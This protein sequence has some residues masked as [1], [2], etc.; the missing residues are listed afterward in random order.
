MDISMA[1][2]ASG[3]ASLSLLCVDDDPQI[4]IL[5]KEL[6]RREPGFIV[7]TSTSA[8]EAL[9]LMETRHYDA[10]LS[11]YYMPEMDGIGLLKEI[12]SRG[13]PALFVIFTGRHI[14]S[15]AIETL[16]NG[17]NF[18]IQKGAA[19]LEDIPKL[20]E[21]L[22]SHRR[23]DENG[24]PV[25][26][27][28]SRF[29]IFT[30]SG[31]ELLASILPDGSITVTNDAWTSELGSE[32]FFAHIPEPDQAEVKKLVA[33]LSPE[34][35]AVYVECQTILRDGKKKR[36]QWG[37]TAF[38]DDGGAP[39]EY[40]AHGR[41]LTGMVTL[42][43]V[44]ETVPGSAGPGKAPLPAGPGGETAR[45]GTAGA[46][47]NGASLARIAKSVAQV[48]YPIFAVD[49]SGTIIAWN[50]AIAD[51]TGVAAESML[52]K[53]DRA[54]AEPVYGRRQP[55]LVDYI[56]P[57]PGDAGQPLPALIKRDG[58]AYI[59]G[60][61]EVTLKGKAMHIVGRATAIR[62][63]SGTIIGAVQ[64][65]LASE[66]HAA[67]TID[68]LLEEEHYLGGVSSVI[69]K[70]TGKGLAGAIAGAIGSASGGY[71]VYATDQRLFIIH[72]PELDA[73]RN[74]GVQFG[75]FLFD[76]LFGTN[77]DIRSRSIRDLEQ[78]K[79]FAVWKNDLVSIEMKKP[80]LLA[81]YLV[82][83]TRNG[84]SFRIY[85]DHQKAF[86]HIEQLMMLFSPE[87][88]KDWTQSEESGE[89]AWIDE[90]QGFDVIGN[91]R[92]DKPVRPQAA[93]GPVTV[94]AHGAGTVSPLAAGDSQNPWADLRT[95]IEPIQYPILAIDRDGKVIA[96]NQAI[97]RLTGIAADAMIGRGDGAYSLPF[98]GEP[99]PMLIDYIVMPPDTDIPAA[100]PAISRE[101]DTFIGDM[102]SV[103][104]GGRP[105]LLWGKG[106]GIYD[107]KGTL[108]AAI[109]SIL[110]SE[111]P[112]PKYADDDLFEERYIGGISSI[113]VKPGREGTA[114]AIAG[115]IGSAPGGYGVYA[116]DQRL[117]IIHNPELDPTKTGGVQFGTFIL[118][119][120]FG[121]TVDTRPF[122][123]GELEGRSVFEVR[124]RDIT[125]IE[126]K[127]PKILAGFL[128]FKTA[129]GESFR[130]YIDHQKAFVHIEHLLR[131]FY[132]EIVLL[133]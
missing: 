106:T 42:G 37:L 18:Y 131:M 112:E 1:A 84:E 94:A 111:T 38:F 133:E 122:S 125:S 31:Q 128:L 75:S 81:G 89:L 35:P 123:I 51:V 103:T 130:V 88:L 65:I 108:V 115:A 56:I 95:A 59:G 34:H 79:I 49:A 129:G 93:A 119:E 52:G 77:V 22:K 98:Y 62:D 91:Y 80:R 54:Y 104:I 64:S 13:I 132:P 68:N 117:F 7:D 78:A 118:D 107:P 45:V 17:G 72:N 66:H 14:A 60:I 120:L 110:V 12:R 27:N 41:D 4:L 28:I 71:G 83:Q 3:S 61:D 32:P 96:W 48:R 9:S 23:H 127:R 55:M 44:K 15:V 70:V 67:G 109:Q 74:N 40:I 99:R 86:S 100:M 87:I 126:M 124:R 25:P 50:D 10:V 8:T 33:A 85:I 39:G 97:A 101:G 16:N 30:H 47:E 20:V 29:G 46:A 24:T 73:S 82:F 90:I 11:D 63:A 102:E 19:F 92:P 2:E 69:L 57:S 121:M 114:G 21:F 26:E 105:M 53:G 76:E 113:T 6:L 116:T 36:L 43:E 5:L 58:D